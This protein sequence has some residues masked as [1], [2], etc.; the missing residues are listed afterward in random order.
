M[1]LVIS[2]GGNVSCSSFAWKEKRAFS[3]KTGHFRYLSVL[4]GTGLVPL[5]RVNQ[6]GGARP[7]CQRASTLRGVSGAGGDGGARVWG[8]GGDKSEEFGGMRGG[9]GSA[10]MITF[11]HGYRSGLQ[12]VWDDSREEA[13]PLPWPLRG[14]TRERGLE[15]LPAFPSSI[16]RRLGV[17]RV[18]D[19]PV[20]MRRGRERRR[21]DVRGNESGSCGPFSAPILLDGTAVGNGTFTVTA[22]DSNV[23]SRVVAVPVV[24]P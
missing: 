15:A 17:E 7:R 4:F 9:A 5:R 1:A 18:R 14:R 11:A 12:D 10:A 3:G 24:N 13:K 2:L 22:L 23:T 16:P 21:S 6:G 20:H 8:G 19:E